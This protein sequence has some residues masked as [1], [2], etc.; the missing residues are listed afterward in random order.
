MKVRADLAFPLG[1]G[2]GKAKAFM[3][4]FAFYT[5]VYIFLSEV[6]YDVPINK[7]MYPIQIYKKKSCKMSCITLNMIL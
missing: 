2:L 1:E 4:I 6:E 5:V 7:K 3:F